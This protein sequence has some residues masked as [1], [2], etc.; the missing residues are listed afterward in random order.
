MMDADD[1]TVIQPL[2]ITPITA[3]ILKQKLRV[4][5]Y[6]SLKDWVQCDNA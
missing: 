3:G 6:W 2:S 5:F 4:F 1:A